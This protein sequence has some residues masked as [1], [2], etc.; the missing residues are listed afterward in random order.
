MQSKR[1]VVRFSLRIEQYLWMYVHCLSSAPGARAL[2]GLN[3]IQKIQVL[4]LAESQSISFFNKKNKIN[5]KLSNTNFLNL[6]S[7]AML[8]NM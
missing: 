5:K 8:A 4:I 1:I 2:A 3:G 6:L 7:M